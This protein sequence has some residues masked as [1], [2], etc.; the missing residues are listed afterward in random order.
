[1][2]KT[3]ILVFSLVLV[4]I[5]GCKKE[6]YTISVQSDTP[7][8]SVSGSGTYEQGTNITISAIPA[9]G[10]KFMTWDDGN[11][12]NPRHITVYH[13]AV[14][15]AKFEKTDDGGGSGGGGG[16]S[17]T[18][19]APTG[20]SA[21]ADCDEGQILLT[22]NTV[23][24]A[25]YY[26]IYWN[27]SSTG[28]YQYL[29]SVEAQYT[30]VY[31]EPTD[32]Y[33]YFKVTAVTSSYEESAMSSYAYCYWN[34][35]GGG[36]GGTT[37]PNAPTGVTATNVGTSS[38]P[39]I[40][41]SWNSVSNATSYKVYRSSSSSGSYSQIGSA[42]SNTY[43]YDNNPLSG[44]NYYKVTAVNSA[45]E[46]SY[47]SYAYY[48][49]TG[50]GGGGGTSY[51]PCPPT[52]TVSGTSSLRVSWTSSTTTGCGRPT[53][54][55]VYHYNYCTSS[56]DLMTTTTSTSYNCPS[57]EVNPGMNLFAVKAINSEGS[58]VNTGTSSSVSLS[59]PSSFS[60]SK[61]GN[62]LN[63]SWSRV[64]RAS[65]Y[66]IFM[67]TSAS[68]NYTIFKQVDGGDETSTSVYYPASSGTYYFKIRSIWECGNNYEV[69]DL[70][71]YK[72]VTY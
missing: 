60:V 56:Y 57:S 72:S 41:I 35:S 13:N 54:Y 28:N 24:N 8:C 23:S 27:S 64:D 58:A 69:S 19:A 45:G 51:S 7:G 42:T 40:K 1:M 66:Q 50:G 43:L 62:Y 12:D 46:S 39:Q 31:I 3:I 17:T 9:E 53:S 11:T 48:N 44:Y 34:C 52:V 14:Y 38:S 59:K 71:S 4:T 65:G 15:V 26:S 29:G 33:N 32:A 18:I 16:G 21:V 30:G 5:M 22:W 68:G 67:S 63:F 55:E 47:S 37:V 70:T 6:Q 36:G 10:Y 61:S 25:A 49:N 20:L 2:R